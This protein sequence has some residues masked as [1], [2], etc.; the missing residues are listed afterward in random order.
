MTV[1]FQTEA[2]SFHGTRNVARLPVLGMI[3]HLQMD[4]NLAHVSRDQIWTL[5]DK[6][7]F[8]ILQR[9]HYLNLRLALG[10]SLFLVEVSLHDDA[11]WRL[12]SR[13][14]LGRA[15]RPEGRLALLC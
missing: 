9:S 11:A 6:P 12:L 14:I 5:V 13:G 4:Y 10:Q 3:L 7:L 1:S 2:F 15:L 8:S